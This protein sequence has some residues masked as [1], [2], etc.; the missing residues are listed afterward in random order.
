[1]S[2]A[3][4]T[5]L[6]L[7]AGAAASSTAEAQEPRIHW[8]V[9]GGYSEP[10]GTTANYLQGGYIVGGGFTVAPSNNSPL[11]FRFDASYSEHNATNN[12]LNINQQATNTQIDNGTGSFW[13][14]TGNL[15]FHVPII[16]GVRG[17]GIA[18]I[19]VYHARVELTQAVPYGYGYY[20]CDPFSGFCDGG[21][22]ALV[23]S[24]GVTKFG[25]NAGVGLEFAL[26]YG[27][28]WFIEARY[29]RINTDT[30]IEYVPIEI[31]Y[32]F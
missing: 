27:Q 8:H 23:A 17:Y 31:G 25:W 26:P 12:L 14:G 16:Y 3:I 9:M 10:L 19:G 7:T 5:S 24:E 1:M 21:G 22:N 4:L 11:D 28:S 15:E 30:P 6:L 20:Y 18:G 13:S 29:H 2:R 32:R